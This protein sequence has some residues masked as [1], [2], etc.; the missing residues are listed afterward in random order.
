MTYTHGH[1]AAQQA[2]ATRTAQNSCGYL[3]PHLR[4]GMSV[5]DVGCGPGSITIDLAELVAPGRVTGVDSTDAPLAAAREAAA[6]RRVTT[7]EFAEADV[8]AL[9][10]AD[11]S[12]DVVHAHQVLQHV[13]D[14]VGALKEMARV[15]RPGG[16]VAARDADYAAMTWWPEPPGLDEWLATYRTMATRNGAQPDAGRRLRAWARAAGLDSVVA[17]AS[18]WCYADADSTRWWAD[19]WTT[20]IHEERFRRQAHECGAT[21]ETLDAMVEGFRAWGSSPDAWWVI[22]NGEIIATL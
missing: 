13:T 17:S 14:P 4:P 5:L 3:L 22:V 21:Q 9:P 1:G 20:R 12:F 2:H 19:S 6:Q 10:Y 16:L 11:A 8:L 7:V 18:T 15:S